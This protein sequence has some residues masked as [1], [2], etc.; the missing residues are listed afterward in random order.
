MKSVDNGT[1]YPLNAS[2]YSTTLKNTLAAVTL[3]PPTTGT[4][5]MKLPPD[6]GAPGQVLTTDGIGSTS[7]TSAGFG[8]VTSVSQTVP[9]FLS[10]TGSPITSTGTLAITYSGTALPIANGGTGLTAVGTPG[11]VLTSDGTNLSYTTPGAGGVTSV[12]QTVPTFLS[13][14][15]SPITSTGTLAITYSGT[16][17]PTANGGTGITTVGTPGQGNS[18]VR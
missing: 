13:T 10:T 18:V 15:G 14:T 1:G 7:W 16:A 6:I 8:S 9:T 5:V 4:Y 11:Q 12:S 17:L 3:A 2:F